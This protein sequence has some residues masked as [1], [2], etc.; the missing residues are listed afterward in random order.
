MPFAV[1]D[2]LKRTGMI[3]S[4]WQPWF[5]K[6]FGGVLPSSYFCF[7]LEFTGF[8]RQKDLIVEWG[9]CLVRDRQVQDRNN[10]I[11]NWYAVPEIV[12]AW[13]VTERLAHIQRT[14]ALEGRAWHVTPA[15]MKADGIHPHKALAFMWDLFQEVMGQGM[16]LASHCGWNCDVD[17][18]TNHFAR[19]LQRAFVIDPNRMF[20][21]GAIEKASQL[22][23]E[24]GLPRDGETLKKYFR[25]I[26]ATRAKGVYANLDTHCVQKY[27][28][29]TRFG[30]DAKA[31]HSASEDAYVVHL[32]MEEFRMLGER[33]V[34]ARAAPPQARVAPPQARVAP[35]QVR[36]ATVSAATSAQRRAGYEADCAAMQKE[37]E[38]RGAAVIP[39]NPMTRFET[40][41]PLNE[42]PPTRVRGQR[43]R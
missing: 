41:S 34:V 8:N 9:H 7:D 17:M 38:A 33:A 4:H 40:D 25:R 19:D 24:Q 27:K 29:D 16:M 13:W 39:E 14:M 37:L 3:I 2:Q 12:P 1:V 36:P 18:L 28:F 26:L 32:L 31:M 5:S 20:D 43:N 15:V 35:P 6:Q 42:R 11:L 30:I 22:P 10:V 21:T 23:P